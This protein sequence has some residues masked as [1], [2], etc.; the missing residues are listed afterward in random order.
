MLDRQRYLMGGILAICFLV[1]PSL[2]QAAEFSAK[3]ITKAGGQ[4]M[5]GKVFMKGEKMRTEV[6]AGGQTS[7]HIVRPD[8][9]LV[10]VLMPAQK[11][12][13]EMPITGEA[14][15]KTLTTLVKDK[16]K[17]KLIGTETVNGF[18]CDKYETTISR[19]GGLTSK[20]YV[21]I[22]KKLG[23]PIKMMSEDGSQLMEYRDIKVGNVAASRFEPPKGYKKMQMPFPMPSMK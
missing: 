19:K 16:A 18:A 11:T 23:M 9:K 12:Y 7:I 21:W 22:A 3:M 20:H 4:E 17:L 6:Q 1:L 13:M 14:Q 5:H 2:A 10:W 15:Q 8:K